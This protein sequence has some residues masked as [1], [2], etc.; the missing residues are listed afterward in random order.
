[1]TD[2]ERV[3]RERDRAI[4]RAVLLE[5]S[6]DTAIARLVDRERERDEA[7]KAAFL[8][9]QGGVDFCPRRTEAQ[10]HTHEAQW[11]WLCG[12]LGGEDGEE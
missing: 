8:L 11:P 3:T 2:L 10:V 4:A 1:M 7:R 9:L 5:T 6:L 12:F